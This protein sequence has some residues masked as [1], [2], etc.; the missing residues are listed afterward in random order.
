MKRIL[1]TGLCVLALGLAVPSVIYAAEAV[2]N[3][4]TVAIFRKKD[5]AAPTQNQDVPSNAPAVPAPDP[6][7]AP[8]QEESPESNQ[9]G[10]FVEIAD[11]D[12]PFYRHNTPN[13][14]NNNNNNNQAP[15]NGTVEP[16]PLPGELPNDTNHPTTRPN[17][18]ER[19]TTRPNQETPSTRP[20]PATPNRRNAR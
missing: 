3:V 18:N 6:T 14:P 17:T 13:T 8:R 16:T 4:E 19:P 20:A 11:L 7:P 15:E 2:S 9:G 1:T 10:I 5:K 12:R